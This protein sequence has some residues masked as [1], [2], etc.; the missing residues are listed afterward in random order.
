MYYRLT[1]FQC[2]ACGG[3]FVVAKKNGFPWFLPG[4][5]GLLR[6]SGKRIQH[7]PKPMPK[8]RSAHGFFAYA[9]QRFK[10][11]KRKGK[12]KICGQKKLP[13]NIITSYLLYTL[14][15]KKSI[16]LRGRFDIFSK[17][18]KI[19]LFSVRSVEF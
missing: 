2:I 4:L 1:L 15:P 8:D 19:L 6:L 14:T 3:S 13:H 5:P 7:S 9:G 18:H 11:L 16:I 10:E 17:R 12:I